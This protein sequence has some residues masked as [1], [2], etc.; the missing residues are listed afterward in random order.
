MDPQ[1]DKRMY[2]LKIKCSRGCVD[3]KFRVAAVRNSLVRRE[4]HCDS[5]GLRTTISI[6]SILFHLT[7]PVRGGGVVSVAF[8]LIAQLQGSAILSYSTTTATSGCINDSIRPTCLR[9]L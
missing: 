7:V 4:T 9:V 3:Q 8:Y 1:S 5:F 6:I 2:V